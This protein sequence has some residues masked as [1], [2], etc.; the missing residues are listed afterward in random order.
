MIRLDTEYDPP[1]PYAC[2]SGEHRIYLHI[3]CDVHDVSA[4]IESAIA[5]LRQLRARLNGDD[6]DYDYEDL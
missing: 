4:E 3:V 2:P 6:Y 5:H 1:E